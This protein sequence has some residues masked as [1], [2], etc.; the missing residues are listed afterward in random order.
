M[1]VAAAYPY[2]HVKVDTRGLTPPATPAFGNVAIVGDADGHG[3]AVAN[4]PVQTS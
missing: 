1:V 2:V 3:V 4:K